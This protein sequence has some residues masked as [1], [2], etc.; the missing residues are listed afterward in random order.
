MSE[1]SAD[2]VSQNNFIS[3]FGNS[4][5]EMNNEKKIIESYINNFEISRQIDKFPLPLLSAQRSILDVFDAILIDKKLDNSTP[6][7]V[8]SFL[9]TDCLHITTIEN[10]FTLSIGTTRVA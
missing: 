7:K 3:K 5:Y 8:R 4:L 1:I 2:D 6:L 9:Y 10:R